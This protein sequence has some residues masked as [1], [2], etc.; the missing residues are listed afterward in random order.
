MP[1]KSCINWMMR[2]LYGALDHVVIWT[3]FIF[4]KFHERHTDPVGQYK[5]MSAKCLLILSVKM[6]SFFMDLPMAELIK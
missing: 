3:D 2:T 4:K 1:Q 5:K 6:V